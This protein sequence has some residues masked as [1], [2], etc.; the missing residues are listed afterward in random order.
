MQRNVGNTFHPDDR[1]AL[2]ALYYAVH[3]LK[4]EAIVVCGQSLCLGRSAVLLLIRSRRQDRK[5]VV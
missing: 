4:V 3:V 2:A 5:S 1:S